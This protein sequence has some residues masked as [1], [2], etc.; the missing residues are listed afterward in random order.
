MTCLKYIGE[1]QVTPVTQIANCMPLF[2]IDEQDTAR[3]A[4]SALLYY[5]DNGHY[6]GHTLRR[7]RT[8]RDYERLS[9]NSY[10]Y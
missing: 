8:G 9:D 1:I 6:A 10:H 3:K 4:Q 2:A 7:G 5:G